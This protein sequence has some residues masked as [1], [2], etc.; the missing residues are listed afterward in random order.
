MNVCPICGETLNQDEIACKKHNLNFAERMKI[1]MDMGILKSINPVG[2][3]AGQKAKKGR[4][5]R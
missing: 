1:L 2:S 3:C 4:R 5:V